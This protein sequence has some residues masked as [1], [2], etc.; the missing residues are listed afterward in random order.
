MPLEELP[1]E[2]GLVVVALE[3]GRRRELEQVAVALIGLGQEGQVVVELLAPAR[4][5]AG[6]VDLAAPDRSFV[7]GLG[8]HV[9][10]GAD[11]RVDAGLAARRV[12]VEDPVHVAVVGDTEGR[13]T[14]LHRRLHQVGDPR[15]PVEHR[16]LGVG[17][18]VGERPC[19]HACVPF[20]GRTSACGP[21][22]CS[23]GCGRVT[24]V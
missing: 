6:V 23:T 21:R 17:V 8:G 24:A 19:C 5:A 10:L 15:R 13:L 12:E 3:V 7:P 16:E 1:V 20:G 9:R 4:V 18:E 2:A 11:H 22:G 14:V